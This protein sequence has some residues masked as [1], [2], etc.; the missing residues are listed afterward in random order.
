M[1][2]GIRISEPK[3]A[4]AIPVLY[5]RNLP[6]VWTPYCVLALLTVYYL[7]IRR[8][9]LNMQHESLL[10]GSRFFVLSLDAPNGRRTYLLP[11]ARVYTA[12]R[13]TPPLM[14]TLM[15]S[16]IVSVVSAKRVSTIAM[17]CVA[18]A[19]LDLE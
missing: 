14:Y 5:V 9:S 3:V 17:L 8:L 1:L 4:E 19:P 7:L 6:A 2:A 15:C 11:K 10:Q 18:E 12:R 16:R 13:Y